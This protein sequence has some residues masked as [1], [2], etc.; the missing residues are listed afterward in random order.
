MKVFSKILGI[1]IVAE[2][3]LG[4]G[5]MVLQ[6]ATNNSLVRTVCSLI[7][8]LLS[9]PLSLINRTYPYYSLE[10]GWVIAA[11]MIGTYL[12]HAIVLYFIYSTLKKR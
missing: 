6:Q 4:M 8:Q 7:M 3:V 12:I 9:L 11:M 1:V 2:L 10:P 5:V